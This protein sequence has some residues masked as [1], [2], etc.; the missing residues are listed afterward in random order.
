[1]RTV[2]TAALLVALGSALPA[3]EVNVPLKPMERDA[4]AIARLADP[5]L[6]PKAVR[7]RPVR[8]A[9]EAKELQTTE[10]AVVADI[11]S[12]PNVR[13]AISQADSKSVYTS[14]NSSGDP[15]RAGDFVGIAVPG[16]AGTVVYAQAG[17]GNPARYLRYFIP[18]QREGTWP[19]SDGRQ[20]RVALVDSDQDFDFSDLDN[21]QLLLDLDGSGDFDA[22]QKSIE[23]RP[24]NKP[25]RLGGSTWA[26][27]V[28]KAGTSLKL[29]PTEDPNA[30][31]LVPLAIGQPAPVWR[32]EDFDGK[33]VNLA[34]FKGRFVFVDIWATWCGPCVAE[35]PN[36]QKASETFK[37]QPIDF[38]S[39]SIDAA[40]SSAVQFIKD[41]KY[42]YRQLWTTGAWESDICKQYQVTGIPSTFLIDP[43]GKLI[44]KEIRGE[45]IE[46]TIAMIGKYNEP[47]GKAFFARK[48]EVALLNDRVQALTEQGKKKEAVAVIDEYLGAH[49]DSPEKEGLERWKSYLVGDE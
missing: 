2:Y 17:G 32:A 25:F 8:D 10:T 47:E 36:I 12:D 5:I 29:T 35:M 42:T 18:T 44:V 16:S 7:T 38:I 4:G 13:V 23:S 3:A 31:D 37:D 1:M 24:A 48:R 43:E 19:L 46:K 45:E 28:D 40:K 27:A 39:I 30:D 22:G 41:K 20:M 33:P 26:I 49:P 6:Q 14:A 21:A 9:A 34:D 15:T 11:S